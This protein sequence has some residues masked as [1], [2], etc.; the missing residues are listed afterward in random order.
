MLKPLLEI[1]RKLI[2]SALLV[3]TV[4]SVYAQSSKKPQKSRLNIGQNAKPTLP[5]KSGI[6]YPILINKEF[7]LGESRYKQTVVNQYFKSQLLSPSVVSSKPVATKSTENPT[8]ESFKLEQNDKVERLFVNDRMSFS[9]AYPNPASVSTSIDY[10]ISNTNSTAKVLVFNMFAT[11]VAEYDLDR[12]ERKIVIPIQDLPE[13]FYYYKLMVDGKM[14]NSK[15]L[16]I[17]H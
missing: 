10:N 1:S 13:G 15:K 14:V 2:L 6:K 9:V 3:L 12:F 7:I 4:G 8:T 16:Q 17:R 5:T 11:Q